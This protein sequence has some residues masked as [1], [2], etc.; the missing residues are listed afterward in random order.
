MRT[1]VRA[2][3]LKLSAFKMWG[4]ETSTNPCFSRCLSHALARQ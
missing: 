4:G 2:G 1:K 3:K